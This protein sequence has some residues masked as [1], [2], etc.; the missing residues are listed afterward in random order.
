MKTFLS[1]I[2]VLLIFIKTNAQCNNP[3]F[4]VTFERIAYTNGNSCTSKI[5]SVLKVT[6]ATKYSRLYVRVF[7]M[8]A[9]TLPLKQKYF[10][11]KHVSSSGTWLYNWYANFHSL[12][13]NRMKIE[14]Y[15]VK[16]SN[17][18]KI[19]VCSKQIY[20]CRTDFDR[21]GISNGVDNCYLT[22]NPSQSDVDND[23]IGDSCD[24]INNNVNA[25]PDL[26]FHSLDIQSTD[27]T[28]EVGGEYIPLVD[29]DS[30]IK[31][32][33]EIKN[34]GNKN[35][36]RQFYIKVYASR[37]NSTYNTSSDFVEQ[38]PVNNLNLNQIHRWKSEFTDIGSRLTSSGSYY[39][40][41]VIDQ[42]SVITESNENNNTKVSKFQFTKRFNKTNT[43][44]KLSID[45]TKN[46]LK[47]NKVYIY[48]SKGKLLKTV[49][50]KENN[51]NSALKGL[52]TGFY[53]IKSRNEKKQIF[54]K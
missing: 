37:N 20:K 52:P 50:T 44:K 12:E 45:S 41:F 10:K 6:N 33:F 39:L 13:M 18:Q 7:D 3:D 42:T 43:K 4:D 51:E 35:I 26:T 11:I 8:D 5:K 16:K 2:L 23:G 46:L 21:D 25:K 40:H 54:I 14:H 27:G 47:N 30:R 19:L 29:L 9:P 28:T 38:R 53:I 15:L 36:T 24:P 48:D 49:L 31:F 32:D 17:G 34:I 1:L 22:Y